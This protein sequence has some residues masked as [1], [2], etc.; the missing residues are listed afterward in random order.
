MAERTNPLHGVRVVNL[1]A[2]SIDDFPLPSLHSVLEAP[3][4][5]EFA[6]VGI[7]ILIEAR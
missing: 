2:V 1:I 3:F 6:G 5:L 7:E 4:F